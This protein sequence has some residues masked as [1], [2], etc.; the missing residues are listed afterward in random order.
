MSVEEYI[1]LECP[2]C[3]NAVSIAVDPKIG[4]YTQTAIYNKNQKTDSAWICLRCE[5]N[6]V[7]KVRQPIDSDPSTR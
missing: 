7:L 3:G 2:E 6:G 1:T 4:R 5:K